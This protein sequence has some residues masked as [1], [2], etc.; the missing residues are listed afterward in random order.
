MSTN[1][2]K[3]FQLLWQL[4]IEIDFTSGNVET[5]LDVTNIIW[6][7][8]DLLSSEKDEAIRN[9]ITKYSPPSFSQAIVESMN[10]QPTRLTFKISSIIIPKYDI[11]SLKSKSSMKSME[12]QFEDDEET[13]DDL[14][15]ELELEFKPLEKTFC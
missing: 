9:N 13:Q 12:F 3:L 15:S 7:K 5:H 6:L 11:R 10:N 4:V 2:S 14:D 1:T 8:S